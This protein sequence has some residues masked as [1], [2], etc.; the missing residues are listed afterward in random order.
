MNHKE[1][2]DLFHS[3][4]ILAEARAFPGT[5]DRGGGGLVGLLLAASTYAINGCCMRRLLRKR[6]KKCFAGTVE[7]VFTLKE[8]PVT[9]VSAV[10][11]SD[12]RG[13]IEPVMYDLS[14]ETGV[15]GE[16][17]AQSANSS[18]NCRKAAIT[19]SAG[20]QAAKTGLIDT[21]CGGDTIHKR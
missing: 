15:G 20:S 10:R 21:E 11:V 9:E 2:C 7:T 5:D 19:Q 8:Y 16:E 1:N 4:V 17:F 13:G 6:V 18:R 14:P 12:R 3:L